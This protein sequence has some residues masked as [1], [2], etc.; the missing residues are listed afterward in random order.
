[1]QSFAT[2]LC[3]VF[4]TVKGSGGRPSLGLVRTASF[5]LL[6][7]ASLPAFAIEPYQNYDRKLK[8]AERVA[9]LGDDL[10]GDEVSLYNGSTTFTQVDMSLPGNSA[11][12]VELRRTFSVSPQGPSPENIGAMANWDVAVPHIHGE[13]GPAGWVAGDGTSLRCSKTTAPPGSG[14]FTADELWSGNR[15]SLPGEGSKIMMVAPSAKLPAPTAPGTWPWITQGNYRIGCLASTANGYAGEGF[16]VLAPNGL[17]YFMNWMVQRDASSMTKPLPGTGQQTSASR[18]TYYLLATRVE[19][20]FGNWVTYQYTGDKLTRIESNDGRWINLSYNGALVSS[21]TSSAGTYS[22]QYQSANYRSGGTSSSYLSG[23]TRP[24]GSTWTF[25]ISGWLYQKYNP[26]LSP[27]PDFSEP[28]DQ[29]DCPEPGEPHGTFGLVIKHPS[30]ATGTFSFG[31]QRH[32]RTRVPKQCSA[33]ATGPTTGYY[34]L[35]IPN[36]FDIYSLQSKQ[37]TGPGLPSMTWS[38]NYDQVWTLG[39]C[40]TNGF[41]MD[42]PPCPTCAPAGQK[43][44]TVTNPDGSLSRHSFGVQYGINEGRLF[45]AET[46]SAGAVMRATENVYHTPVAADLV[47]ASM[48]SQLSSASFDP[49][50]DKVIPVRSTVITQDGATFSRNV[51][52]GCQGAGTYCFDALARP[53]ATTKL[54]SLGYTRTETSEYHDNT[55]YW[56]LGQGARVRCTAPSSP[57]PTGCG[58]TGTTV[59]ETTYDALARPTGQ[60]SFGMLKQTLGYYTDGTVAT[61]KDGNNNVITLSSW[62]RGIPRSIAYPDSTAQSATVNDVGWITSITD[63]NGYVTGYGYDAMGRLASVVYPTGDTTVWNTTTQ[64]FEQVAGTEYGIPTGHWRQTVSTGNARKITYYD[65]LWRPLVTREYDAANE[66]ATK[67]FQRFTYDH[68]GRTTFASYPGTTDALTTGNW[69]AYDALGR[70]TSTS[71]DSELSPSLL[72]TTIQYLTGF[73][74]QVTNPRGFSTVTQ[75]QVF[76]VPSTDSPSGITQSAGA[77]T[78][79]TEIHRDIFGKPQRIRKR[80]ASGSLFVD[81]H[82]VYQA[83]QQLCKVIE[84]ETGATVFG[85]DWAGNMTHSA[86]GLYGYGDTG[87]CNQSEAWASGRAVVRTYNNMNRL[88][89]LAFPGGSGNQSW[90]YWPDGLPYKITTH[91]DGLN[92]GI[93]QNTYA[94]NKRRMLT[95]ESSTQLGWYTWGLGYAYDANGS[96]STQT[97]PAGLA[98]SYAPNALGQPT[99]VR[100]QSTYA[101]ATGVNYYPNGAIKQF[102]YGNG[103][104][105]SMAQN[106]RQLP[107]R[108]LSSGIADLRYDYDQNGNVTVIGDETPGRNNG[109]YSR[110]MTYD[111][112]DRLTAAGSCMF[113]GD[114]WHRFTYDALDNMKSWKLPGVKDY[115]EYVYDV[116]N[117]LGNIKNSGGATVVGFEYDPQGNLANK[118]GQAYQFDYGNRL[119]SVVG[120]ENYRYDGH[121]RRVL[122]WDVASTHSILSMYS[123]GGQVMYQEDYKNAKNQENIYLAGSLIAI[124]EWAHSNV[125]SVKFQHTDALGSPIAVTNQAGVVIERND[126]EPYGAI[127]GKP[128]YDAMGFTGHKQDGATGL[129]YMQQRYYDPTVGRFLSVDPVTALSS[130]VGMFNRYK[131]AANNPYRFVDPDGRMIMGIGEREQSSCQVDPACANA[132]SAGDESRTRG[133]FND[134]KQDG[135]TA[136]NDLAYSHLEKKAGPDGVVDL[137]MAEFGQILDYE[138][139]A[140]KLDSDLRGGFAN[141]PARETLWEARY[142]DSIFYGQFGGTLYRVLR[143]GGSPIGPYPGGDFNYIK[144]GM[145][146]AASGDSRMEMRVI[147]RGW[148]AF[149]GAGTYSHTPQ[150]LHLADIGYFFYRNRENAND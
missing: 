30:G 117:R 5:L 109:S 116:Q 97:Y 9:P 70:P 126:Y 87:A 15:L 27:V 76:D 144:Q 130:P 18:K 105:H 19:D 62:Y 132:L 96:L 118:S 119:R 52:A 51:V 59:S 90:E 40:R 42:F 45:K 6:L 107:Q 121:G 31:Y 69:T 79:V 112:L 47:P 138:S 82:Y 123:N 145:T 55:Y 124:R 35:K 142:A 100:D 108:V 23:V 28:A 80:N 120:K 95:G 58:P 84:P 81:R 122:A 137:T 39:F 2:A 149:P 72:T 131:Y 67:R 110:W 98:I 134:A 63:Q 53:T 68:A 103:I 102:T 44:V 94:Y 32:Y 104:V 99:E 11:L 13:F 148:N 60:Y 1:M 8:T 143:E 21:A 61:V 29:M 22:Y 133:A 16:L 129:T 36:F 139:A 3:A 4:T 114:C 48:A 73:Q 92:A 86:A 46:L 75:Y 115:A 147:I 57:L 111:G 41:C 135:L 17:K 125:L 43:F 141:L 93:V 136:A 7:L 74:Q 83:D 12:P 25:A 10:F 88:T 66:T 140:T 128:T 77:D 34:Q 24:D 106:A 89:A 14:Y 26:T 50:A 38:Y 101:Y 71:Q 78:S 65:G 49:L 91:N 56:V 146:F 113:G 150:R 33:W 20:R 37:I 85:Y 127:I 54:S 64:V